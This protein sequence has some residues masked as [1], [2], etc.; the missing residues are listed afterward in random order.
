MC[1]IPHEDPQRSP[2]NPQ[3]PGERAGQ[4]SAWGE[5]GDT[6]LTAPE[7]S[8]TS[9]PIFTD[10]GGQWARGDRGYT[11]QGTKEQQQNP[12]AGAWPGK[13]PP[14]AASIHPT[15]AGDWVQVRPVLLDWKTL[16]RGRL[17]PRR[18]L[19]PRSDPTMANNPSAS[20]L[21]F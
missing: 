2:G 16:R 19:V 6:C 9:V 17:C 13:D 1:R 8:P 4:P 5:Q 20:M 18:E 12:M 10:R 21:C 11:A 14:S 3:T 7:I 15:P